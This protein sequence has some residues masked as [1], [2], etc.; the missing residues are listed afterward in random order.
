[1]PTIHLALKPGTN[2]PLLNAMACTI[3]EE[4]LCDEPQSCAS[5]SASWEEFREF[6]R[7]FAPEKVAS[8]LR[9]RGEADPPARR[10]FTRRQSRPCVST[11]SA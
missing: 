3:V 10:D 5:A 8:D 11:A 7:E 9:R 4:E 6:I 2:V 1:M